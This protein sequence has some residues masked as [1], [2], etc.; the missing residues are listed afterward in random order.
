M[1]VGLPS[2]SS[3][4][5]LFAVPLASCIDSSIAKLSLAVL[6]R[7]SLVDFA[8]EWRSLS[9]G[10]RRMKKS[11]AF[12]LKRYVRDGELRAGLRREESVFFLFLPRPHGLGSISSAP[13]G[14]PPQRTQKPSG[15]ID[16]R[17]WPNCRS[18]QTTGP[19]RTQLRDYCPTPGATHLC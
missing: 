16:L 5:S 6:R 19:R 1:H 9:T 8:R 4:L 18:R 10:I 12:S 3:R 2:I 13:Y 11:K 17:G 7:R 14:A 15:D